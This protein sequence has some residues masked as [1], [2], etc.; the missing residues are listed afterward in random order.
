MSD[1]LTLIAWLKTP[2]INLMIGASLAPLNKSSVG[3][4]VFAKD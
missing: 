3:A 2:L 4:N 1:A